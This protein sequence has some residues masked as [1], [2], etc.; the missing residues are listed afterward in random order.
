MPTHNAKALIPS[1]LRP[2]DPRLVRRRARFNG[3]LP[4]R[5]SAERRPAERPRSAQ[6]RNAAQSSVVRSSGTG[7]RNNAGERSNGAPFS[8]GARHHR[9]GLGR[10]A[11]VSAGNGR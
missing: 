11:L 1:V 6:R 9:S 4:A 5:L 8:S 10:S 7:P 2:R 3:G